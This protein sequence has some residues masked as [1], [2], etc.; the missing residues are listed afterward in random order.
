MIGNPRAYN[1]SLPACRTKI[2]S[3]FEAIIQCCQLAG[4]SIGSV[5]LLRSIWL[6]FVFALPLAAVSLP[7]A[8]ALQSFSN[9][10]NTSSIRHSEPEPPN[11]S[12][13]LLTRHST[14]T[15]SKDSELHLSY[16]PWVYRGLR[17]T[18]VSWKSCLIHHWE[19]I[20]QHS[21]F[22]Y[23]YAALFIVT[24]GKQSL[25]ILIQYAAQRFG[26]VNIALVS[27]SP[28]L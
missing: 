23:A 19:L 22:R 26:D 14:N 21:L 16:E 18:V 27:H 3:Y 15:N 17:A 5:L 4:P 28:P 25:H 1:R 7:L 12:S 8:L 10:P 24:L 2:F 6:P 13:S 20:S 9:T 11:E